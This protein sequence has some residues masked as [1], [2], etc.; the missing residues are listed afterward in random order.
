MHVAT[1]DA[2]YREFLRDGRSLSEPIVRHNAHAE[3]CIP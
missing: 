2:V 3:S 1:L